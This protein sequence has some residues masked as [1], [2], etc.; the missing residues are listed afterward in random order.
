MSIDDI[1]ILKHS[2]FIFKLFSFTMAFYYESIDLDLQKNYTHLQYDALEDL[3]GDQLA[4]TVSEQ[5][6]TMA[7]SGQ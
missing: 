4:Y 6:Q 5:A 1:H 3:T 2:K 7:E